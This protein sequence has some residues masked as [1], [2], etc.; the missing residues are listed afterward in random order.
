MTEQTVINQRWVAF[1][2]VGAVGSIHRTEQGFAVTLL[3]DERIV[4]T[5]PSLDIAKRA[6][7]AQLEPGSE[8]PEFREH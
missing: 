4:G 1:G 7:H 6:L 5:Y 2:P 3:A 8:R